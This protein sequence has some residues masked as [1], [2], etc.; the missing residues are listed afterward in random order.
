MT[1]LK[2]K[3]AQ[4]ELVKIVSAGNINDPLSVAYR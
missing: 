3:N 2:V 1:G 4:E